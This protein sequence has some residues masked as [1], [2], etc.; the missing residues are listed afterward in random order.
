MS[1]PSWVQYF[2]ALTTVIALIV[3]VIAFA[4]WRTAHQRAVLDL[5]DKR[6]DV[7]DALTAVISQI[8][9]EGKATFQDLIDY[10]RA[11]DR[12]QFL[13]RKPV[14]TYLLGIKETIIHLRRVEVRQSNVDATQAA[15]AD[16]EADDLTKMAEFH[17]HLTLLV[18]PYLKMHQKAPPF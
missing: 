18:K 1:V 7:Y 3:A 11:V 14:T 5:F 10:S 4:Q 6:M 12:A 17:Q 13:F 8:M 2:Q 15:A 9:R 16:L